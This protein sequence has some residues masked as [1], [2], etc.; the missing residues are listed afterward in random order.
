MRWPTAAPAKAMI[1]SVLNST[2]KAFAP[3]LKIIAPWREWD[4]RSRSDA[5]AYA[6]ARNDS[7]HGDSRE[8]LQ[9]RYQHLAHQP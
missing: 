5:I 7:R 3:Q 6:N 9:P 8:D 1:R 4:I 2:Y